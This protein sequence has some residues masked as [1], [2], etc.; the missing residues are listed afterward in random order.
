VRTGSGNS[1]TLSIR[2]SFTNNT[3]F[4]FDYLAFRVI[5]MTTLNSPNTL[6]GQAQLRLVTSGDAE[7][8]TNSLG[9]TVVIRGSI[10]EFDDGT[11]PDQQNGGGLNTTVAVNLGQTLILP[12][13]T[14]DVQFLLNV[15]QSGTFRF[16]VFA[17]G[18]PSAAP[19]PATSRGSG[20]FSEQLANRKSSPRRL[21]D[22]SGRVNAL[23]NRRPIRKLPRR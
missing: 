3:P 12:G 10:L 9:R 21:I 14:V 7:T 19:R 13:E 17:E 2:R 8:F 16:Y 15:V 23:L 22:R 20:K 5:D 6:P 4:T 1:G 11:E 18:F